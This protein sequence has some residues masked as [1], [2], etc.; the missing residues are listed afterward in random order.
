MTPDVQ[1]RVH[2]AHPEL[3]FMSLAGAPMQYNKKTL[4]GREERED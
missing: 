3:A 1:Q 4:E 2:E